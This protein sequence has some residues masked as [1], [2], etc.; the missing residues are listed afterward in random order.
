MADQKKPNRKRLSGDICRRETYAGDG[1]QRHL[2]WDTDTPGLGLRV[3]PS[4]RKAFIFSFRTPGGTKRLMTLGDFG[5]L[6]ADQA[7]SRARKL[8]VDVDDGKDPLEEKG[9]AALGDTLNDLIKKY[10]SDYAEPRKKTWAKDKRRLD[11]HIPSR[12]KARKAKAITRAE[13]ASLNASIG[14]KTPYEA[15]RLIEIVRRMFNLAKVWGIL[16]EGDPNPAEGIDKF[17]ER[18]RKRFATQTEMPEIAAAIDGVPNIYI[19]AAIWLYLLT[20]VR[21][22]ELLQAKRADVDFTRAMLRLPETKS[23]DEQR[24]ALNA[25]AIAIIQSL[26]ELED[27]P[28]L[29]PSTKR[30]GRHLVNIDKRWGE[31]RKAAGVE[32]LRL[33]DLRRTV[34]SWL[35]QGGVDLNRIKEALRHQNIATTLTYARLG[36]DPARDAM[37]EH[38]RQILEAAG[39]TGPVA[40]DDGKT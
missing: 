35:S 5:D 26:P 33:H 22:S 18:K 2:L 6:T 28:Y 34:G 13:V 19:R 16:G 12:W 39:R 27:N 10:I 32:D 7:R 14:S 20:G 21:K 31:V 29:L 23:G 4:G 37:E 36:D 9:R 1:K 3:Y 8:R 40:V 17:R 15:N 25:P 30:K 11:N 24:A 38:G